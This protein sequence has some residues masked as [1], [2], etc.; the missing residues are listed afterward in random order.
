MLL[1]RQEKHA[2]N[3]FA[4][5]YSAKYGSQGERQR[6]TYRCKQGSPSP[7]SGNIAAPRIRYCSGLCQD[8]GGSS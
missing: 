4:G 5:V 8:R 6:V 3:I 7:A 1:R 2:D